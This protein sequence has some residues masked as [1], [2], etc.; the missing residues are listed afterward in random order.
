MRASLTL[1]TQI[2]PLTVTELD[3]AIAALDWG[4]RAAAARKTPLLAEAARQIAAYLAGRLRTFELPL[5]ISGSPFQACVFEAM[6]AIPYGRVMSYGEL[7]RVVDSAP[8]AIGGACGA[9]PLPILVPCH[10]VVASGHRL[11][12]YSGHGGLD[13]KRFLLRIEGAAVDLR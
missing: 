3:G 13:T 7:A 11:G 5:L 6:R 9:N 2:G 10:R 1:K 12:G 8:R 4:T